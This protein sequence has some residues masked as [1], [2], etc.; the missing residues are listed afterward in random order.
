MPQSLPSDMIYVIDI[1]EIKGFKASFVYNFFTSD[2]TQREINENTL[3]LLNSINLED[4]NRENTR[5]LLSTR[6]P[7]YVVF[8]WKKPR[9]TLPG[10][11]A[12]ESDSLIRRGVS[13]QDSSFSIKKYYDKI[14]SEDSL[15]LKRY[16]NATF[17][18]GDIE[19][20]LKELMTVSANIMAPLT[21][22]S[23]ST[24]DLSDALPR[25]MN[26]D[27]PYSLI[28]QEDL[29]FDANDSRDERRQSFI[30]RNAELLKD[31]GVK[32]K[33]GARALPQVIK[34]SM[35]DPLSWY[36]AD[37][38]SLKSEAQNLAAN[39]QFQQTSQV[40]VP[41]IGII[42]SN[43]AD[44]K[45]RLQA[46]I[47]GYVIEKWEV[48]PWGDRQLEPIIIENEKVANAYDFKVKY[49]TT[50]KYKIKAIA[51]FNVPAI[52]IDT[53]DVAIMQMLV[54]SKPTN[55]KILKAEDKN[56]PPP[57]T[58]TNFTWNYETGQLLIHWTF[59]PNPQRD[60]K[61]F[62]VFRRKK[63]EHPF[64]LIKEYDF[65]DS[66]SEEVQKEK[67]MHGLSTKLLDADNRPMPLTFY[68]DEDFT[69]DS[70][71]IY[72]LCSID[73]HG[74]TSCY[75]PQFEVKFDKFK[76]QLIKKIISHSGAPKAYPNLYLEGTGFLDVA[77]VE[78][79]FTK[80]MHLYFTPPFYYLRDENE[81]KKPVLST[82]Q[83]NGKYKF[84]F[85]NADNQ[86]AESITIEIDDQLSDIN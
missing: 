31:L 84:F 83:K 58:D 48:T 66:F 21:P 45:Q 13:S 54:S 43:N 4:P 60:I 1:P 63:V 5:S 17:G 61:K 74:I 18:D 25:E 32:V 70:N 59:P 75:G 37:L 77:N 44:Q 9:L 36:K 81:N 68:V 19:E 15:T 14:V 69:K 11:V 29:N 73:A 53:N 28:R 22:R 64:E 20:K 23:N 39:Q 67:V 2:E 47:V 56:A 76:N 34:A 24:R 72:A 65:N 85:I 57:P 6:A 42:P 46:E 55:A 12:S 27:L 38:F 41:R 3:D 62:Q 30:N 33:L 86:K 71:F 82:K 16:V 50:Y 80:R 40:V 7:R 26:L 51:L 52:D 49:G 79:T 10:E 35:K 8:S 78:G